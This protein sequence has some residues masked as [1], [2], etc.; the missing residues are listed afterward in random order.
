MD[1]EFFSSDL[2]TTLV[3][4]DW[5]SLQLDDDTDLMLYRIRGKPGAG[6]DWL[7]GSFI[8][9]SGTVRPLAA[10]AIAI[11]PRRTWTSPKTGAVY[12]SGWDITI[13][14]LEMSLK[15]SPD[16]DDQE[17][18][19]RG[20]TGVVYWEGSVSVSGTRA[21]RALA[22]V[23]YAELTGYDGRTPMRGAAR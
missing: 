7:S 20:S 13:E 12:P 16:R 10:E 21:G 4:W 14:P 8:D 17:L 9:A 6:R 11:G 15:L 1:H 18:D 2:D 19:T 5:F 22:G 3:G 23:G